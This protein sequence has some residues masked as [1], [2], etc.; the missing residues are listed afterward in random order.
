[1]SKLKTVSFSSLRYKLLIPIMIVLLIV[2][3][4]MHEVITNVTRKKS[5]KQTEELS[6]SEARRIASETDAYF[7]EAKSIVYVLSQSFL[8]LR[9]N[10]LKS[11]QL[12]LNTL[13]EVLLEKRNIYALFTMWES[14]AF[15][16]LD[17]EYGKRYGQPTGRFSA[18]AYWVGDSIY[19][20]DHNVA[21]SEIPAYLSDGSNDEFED[22]Y[23]LLPKKTRKLMITE[24][25]LYSYTKS[26]ADIVLMSSVVHPIIHEDEFL[27][28]VGVDIDIE[29]LKNVVLKRGASSQ[30]DYSIVTAEGS[31]LANN[32][33]ALVG[34]NVDSITALSFSVIQDSL[35]KVDYLVSS[36]YSISQ[37]QDITQ[38]FLPVSMQGVHS[39]WLVMVQIPTDEIYADSKRLSSVV[40]IVS[41]LSLLLLMVIIYLVA[42][43]IIRPIEAIAEF[44]KRLAAGEL[45]TRIK[46]DRNDELGRL[47]ETLHFMAEELYKHTHNLELLVQE[48]TEEIAT[49]NEE[50]NAINEDL[51]D[52]NVTIVEKNAELEAVIKSL[53]EAQYKLIQSEKMASLGTLTAGVAHEI[54]NPLN[55]LMGAYVGLSNF[56]RK[57]NIS[58]EKKLTVLLASIKSGVDKITEIV[59]GLNQFS[60]TNSDNN[61]ECDIHSIVDNCLVMLHNK[62]KYHIEVVKDYVDEKII[63]KGNVG[64]LHQVFLNIIDNAIYASEKDQKIL[65]VSSVENDMVRIEIS[66]SGSGISKEQISQVIEPF[67]TT[68]PPG[69]GT[70][71]GL[72]IAYSIVA[73]HN[74]VL[75][76]E[77]EINKG[78]KVIVKL[79]LDI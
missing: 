29:F 14:N 18:S 71:L 37:K 24:P 13:E 76:F 57:N 66:D 44:T 36:H 31:M 3:A 69:K 39:S 12:V 49:A 16:N 42:N 65:I 78:T 9:N 32:N 70:G 2:F 79:P 51:Y 19:F 45:T 20:Q 40:T 73:E 53:K 7:S 1:M 55:Y 50:L 5:V 34:V 48:K 10:T 38:Y 23:Y 62:I 11:R 27:G 59:K 75:E 43:G 6:L 21:V 61:E 46:V 68:K 72:S 30:M 60:R 56:F 28:V 15:D 77:S 8:T 64:K 25:Y 52:K 17:E 67:F 54:N 63:I 47:I 35:K 26:N 74:G 58:D 4:I 41:L 22:E 33:S